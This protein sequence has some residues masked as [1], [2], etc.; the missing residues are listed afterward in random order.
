MSVQGHMTNSMHRLSREWLHSGIYRA[1]KFCIASCLSYSRRKSQG[2]IK[3][4]QK[5]KIPQQW[6][7][8][9]RLDD[10][11]RLIYWV[12]YTPVCGPFMTTSAAVPDADDAVVSHPSGHVDRLTSLVGLRCVN[13]V[14]NAGRHVQ[15]GFANFQRKTNQKQRRTFFSILHIFDLQ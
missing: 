7:Y 3:V 2:Q 14:R 4:A 1:T 13:L 9:N 5:N 15:M 10:D 6:Q 11:S 8:K 12:K